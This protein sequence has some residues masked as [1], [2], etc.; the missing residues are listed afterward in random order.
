MFC[1]A[2]QLCPMVYLPLQSNRLLAIH[3]FIQ[4]CMI[5]RSSEADG[6]YDRTGGIVILGVVIECTM[7]VTGAQ[8]KTTIIRNQFNGWGDSSSPFFFLLYGL[9]LG[10]CLMLYCTLSDL[11]STSEFASCTRNSVRSESPSGVYCQVN[12]YNSNIISALARQ[13]LH[14]CD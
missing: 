1:S 9:R 5:T 14:K 4:C 3:I 10:A 6:T 11:R 13:T 12:A 2:D 7:P 8:H